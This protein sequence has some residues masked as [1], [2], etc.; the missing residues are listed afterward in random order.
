MLYAIFSLCR[1]AKYVPLIYH[2]HK[3]KSI[4]GLSFDLIFWTSLSALLRAIHVLLLRYNATTREQYA[5]R[6]PL[7]PVPDETF[8]TAKGFP[9][10]SPPGASLTE[11]VIL[12][13][14]V[15]LMGGYCGLYQTRKLYWRSRT[16]AQSISGITLIFLV[17]VFFL[18]PCSLY[19][20]WG[21]HLNWLDC[22]Y[23]LYTVGE[24]AGWFQY[25]PQ[26]SVNFMCQS[27]AG[28][29]IWYLAVDSAGIV[30]LW[31]CLVAKCYHFRDARELAWPNSLFFYALF[32]TVALLKLL[33][34]H[35][36]IYRHRKVRSK[37]IR[38]EE[39]ELVEI[40]QRTC[41]LRHKT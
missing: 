5:L 6:F 31:M 16:E 38:G 12:L 33:S 20:M 14:T 3:R 9:P 26:I 21:S 19:F 23:Y 22:A 18:L 25:I 13:G 24:V 2:N 30:A 29:S 35:F 7:T 37:R 11:L 8:V 39:Y 41:R 34:Q 28:L 32:T 36:L 4:A 1:V 17:I 40:P 27:T 15:T 10:A